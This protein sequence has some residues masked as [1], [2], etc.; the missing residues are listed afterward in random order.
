METILFWAFTL[1]LFQNTLVSNAHLQTMSF[2][3][4]YEARMKSL[5][6]M[7]IACA[8]APVQVAFGNFFRAV[9]TLFGIVSTLQ[10]RHS[11]PARPHPLDHEVA[12]PFKYRSPSRV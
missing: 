6:N 7:D 5:A 11:L 2:M 12:T 8:A 3:Q 9:V 10:V 1:A 4:L